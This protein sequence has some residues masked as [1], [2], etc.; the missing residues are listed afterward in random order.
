MIEKI[1]HPFAP[2]FDANSKILILGSMPSPKSRENGF[3]YGHKQNRFWRVLSALFNEPI[4]DDI[5]SKTQFLLRHN[6]ALWD[7]IESCKIVGAS[8]NSIKDVKVNDLRVI[9]SKT[10]IVAIFTLGTAATKYLKK[11]TN[12]NSIKLPSTSPANCAISFE[13]LCDEFKIILKFL[14]N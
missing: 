4:L 1:V 8:D 11:Y 12:L 6:I 5:N 14:R 7:V 9:L 13:K 3:Y 10:K 2:V